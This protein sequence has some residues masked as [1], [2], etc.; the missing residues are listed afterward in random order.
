M[1]LVHGTAAACPPHHWLIGN[2]LTSEGTVERWSC[3]RCGTIRE[4]L[5]SRRRPAPISERRYVGD[6]DDV[7]GVYLGH[8]GERVA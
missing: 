7:L 1:E 3:Q 2:E 8:G 4:R 6:D 5:I